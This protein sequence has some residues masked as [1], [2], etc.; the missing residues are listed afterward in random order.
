MTRPDPI[1]EA[2]ALVA[3]DREQLLAELNRPR[4]SQHHEYA[5]T[6]WLH[7]Y[8]W[9]IERTT[10]AKFATVAVGRTLTERGAIHAKH[11]A[12]VRELNR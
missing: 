7:R 8:R 9:W 6:S 12:Y 5:R 3:A 4:I 10:G 11:R 1:D 2:L